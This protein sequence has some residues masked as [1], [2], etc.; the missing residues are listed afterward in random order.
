MKNNI[1]CVAT[2]FSGDPPKRNQRIMPSRK[3]AKGKARKAAKEAKEA[4]AAKESRTVVNVAAASQ[5]HVQEESLNA[6]MQQLRISAPSP[7]MCRHGYPPL[8]TGDE[9]ICLEFINEYMIV[10]TWGKVSALR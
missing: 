3:K 4:E 10:S 5:Q 6:M 1:I 2:I 7:T 9:K 8:S